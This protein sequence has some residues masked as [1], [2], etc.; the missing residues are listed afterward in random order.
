M[1]WSVVSDGA[2]PAPVTESS[3]LSA[4]IAAHYASTP[5]SLVKTA[6]KFGVSDRRVR[7]ALAEHGVAVRPLPREG[8]QYSL[9]G[10]EAQILARAR[11]GEP[12]RQIG[13][14][15]GVGHEVVRKL[16]IR[17]GVP[18]GPKVRPED[19]PTDG[20]LA[21]MIRRWNEGASVP[22]IAGEVGHGEVWVR[23]Y[24]TRAGVELV[25][26]HRNTRPDEVRAEA[27]RIVR[28]GGSYHRAAAA[29]GASPTSVARWARA[30]G[31]VSTARGGRRRSQRPPA[32][33]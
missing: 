17:N 19:P 18:R 11:R 26:R 10:K 3:P 23:K 29:V 5:T 7:A 28:E 20:V 6:R 12:L 32:D 13:S 16:L 27:V 2:A 8:S 33:R 21:H 4:R 14:S 25:R 15:L 31:V 24:L 22:E 9:V 30:A 1:P